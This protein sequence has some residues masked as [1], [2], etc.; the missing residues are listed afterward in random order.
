MGQSA[1]L[2]VADWQ[3]MIPFAS[4]P[5]HSWTQILMNGGQAGPGGAIKLAGGYGGIGKL[6][7]CPEAPLPIDNPPTPSF[8]TAHLQWTN[9]PE[10]GPGISGSYGINGWI[11]SVGGSDVPTLMSMAN[12]RGT[13]SST[14]NFFHNAALGKNG[15]VVPVVI[16]CNWRQVF[17]KEN[18]FVPPNTESPPGGDLVDHPI[19]RV[20][21]NRHNKAVNVSYLD[22]H[23][24]TVRLEMLWTLRWSAGWSR[25]KPALVP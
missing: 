2:Y 4:D 3:R 23:A 12:S 21:L 16:D 1:Q 19:A 13:I 9:S 20:V 10:T 22:G 14:G 11:Y 17:A 5:V 15:S 8:G 24:D 7:I 25:N 18:D 6:R